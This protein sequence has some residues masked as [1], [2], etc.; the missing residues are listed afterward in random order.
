VKVQCLIGTE[1]PH[2]FEA[3]FLPRLRLMSVRLDGRVVYR[4]CTYLPWAS[5]RPKEF[6]SDAPEVHFYFVEPPGFIDPETADVRRDY[7]VWLDGKPFI[8]CGET[9]DPRRPTEHSDT[10]WPTT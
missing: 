8:T 2:S 4:H 7:R 5:R 9:P 3:S 1:A 6:R 10:Q